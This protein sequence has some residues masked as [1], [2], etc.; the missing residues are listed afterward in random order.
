MASERLRNLL[1]EGDF[2]SLFIGEMGW[3]RPP[4]LSVRP[5]VGSDL[6]PVPIADKRGVTAFVVACA[7]GMPLRAHQHQVVRSLRKASRDQLI[8]FASADEHRWLWPEQRP[9]GV[10]YRLVDHAYPSDAPSE[11]V[12]QR[13]DRASFSLAEEASLTSSKVLDRV[14]R[15]FNAEKVTRSFYREFAKQHRSFAAAIEGIDDDSDRDWYASVL[16]NRLMFIYFIQQRG[17][18]DRDTEYLR[19]RLAMV[20][21]EFADSD[22]PDYAYWEHFLLPLFHEGLGRAAE[23]ED[24]R[25]ARLIGTVPFINGGVFEMHEIESRWWDHLW[26]ADDAFK[27]LYEFFDEWRWHLDEHPSG[28]DNEINPDVLG[29]IFEQYVNQKDYGAYYTK[30]DVTGYMAASAILPAVAD[31]LVAAG[32]DDPALLLAGSGDAYLHDSN[33]HGIEFPTSGTD[34]ARR[35]RCEVDARS[36]CRRSGM[37]GRGSGAAAMR[38][39]TSIC[40]PRAST[41]RCPASAGAMW[42][43]G[44][45]AGGARSSCCRARSAHGRSM[46]RSPRTSTSRS[47]CATT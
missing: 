32:L 21:A 3:D 42:C 46:T 14:R 26:I 17:F 25:S 34:G 12:L 23:P 16:L 40:R 45:S 19:S 28:D 22:D 11:A 39:S 33:G 37:A 20:R 36:I 15:S 1:A 24:R 18:L 2:E 6:C 38:P 41:W 8:V 29:Y 35:R 13:L 47:C 10:G 31:R 7:D 5:A 27:R 4:P 30:P 44:A 43:T 9:S